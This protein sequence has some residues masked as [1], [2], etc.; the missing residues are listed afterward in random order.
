VSEG[1]LDGM[2]YVLNC[3]SLNTPT[4]VNLDSGI[5]ENLESP[6]EEEVYQSLVEHFDNSCII[7]QL[8]IGGFRI[9]LVYDCGLPN[10]PKIAIEC[11]GAK[12]HSS[13][14][15]YLYDIHRQKIIESQGFVFHRIWSTNWWR[16]YKK[17]EDK[18][19][20]FIR[21]TIDSFNAENQN[22][23][24]LTADA[25]ND[26]IV[27][28]S[29]FSNIKSVDEYYESENEH[30]EQFQ[31]EEDDDDDKAIK[32]GS[33]VKLNYINNDKVVTILISD[34]QLAKNEV[35]NGIQKINSKS[36]LALSLNKKHKGEIVKI[37]N[38]DNYVEILDVQN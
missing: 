19:V 34:N 31:E 27:S 5:G 25:F 12:Y 13:K 8:K 3:L 21:S 24:D 35:V 26:E 36:P 10:V 30:L 23:L 37:G 14:E 7:P 9:D 32:I 6:F 11:D 28:F 29:Q 15:A 17:E 22:N 18:L 20:K 38:L 16:D 33:I 1:N 4:S 2:N